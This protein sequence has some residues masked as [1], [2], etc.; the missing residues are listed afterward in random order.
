MLL[1]LIRHPRLD[2][3]SGI[4]Y[5]QSDIAADHAHCLQLADE[6]RLLLPEKLSV[7]SSPLQRCQT[8]A[9][10]LHPAPELDARLMEK[11]F[12]NWEMQAWD[13]IPRA[14]IDAWVLDVIAYAP[15]GGE[16]VLMM[17]R[18]V[19]SFLMDLPMRADLAGT[20]LA[21]LTHGGP[22]SMILAYQFGMTAEDLASAVAKKR[23]SLDF[24]ECVQV[25]INLC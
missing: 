18:R 2:I 3:A 16:S 20:E 15:T 6:L 23:K 14:E 19:L 21:L 7:I 8:L 12:G 22:S 17:A 24:G 25:Q 10:M 11:H 4:C 9:H 1:H 5:G 13:D